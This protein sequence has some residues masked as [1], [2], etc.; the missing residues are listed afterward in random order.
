M[1]Q[2]HCS[3]CDWIV[4]GFTIKD[5]QHRMRMHQMKHSEEEIKVSKLNNKEVKK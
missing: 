4:E 2:E 5:L 3:V 1:R